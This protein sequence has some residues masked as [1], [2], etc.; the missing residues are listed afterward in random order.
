MHAMTAGDERD[1]AVSPMRY[2]L[3]LRKLGAWLD[4]LLAY[5]IA[6]SEVPGGFVVRYH[7]QAM[8]PVFAERYFSIQEIAGMRLGDL[9]LRR[10]LAGRIGKRLQGMAREPGG[11]QDLFRAIGH[12]LDVMRAS[13]V[14]ALEGEV[15]DTLILTFDE[16]VEVPKRLELGPLDRAVV[17]VRARSRRRAGKARLPWR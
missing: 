5:R 12:E 3:S 17:R 9:G 7:Q 13:G 8:E 14:V 6:I 11:Y 1:N 10:R 4:A 16:Q 2:E 15:D